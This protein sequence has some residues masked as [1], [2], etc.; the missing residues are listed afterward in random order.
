MS[1]HASKQLSWL[2]RHGAGE[3]GL[4]MDAA[5]WAEIADVLRALDMSRAALMEAVEHNDKGRL[6]VRGGR[7]R[8]CQGHSLAGMPVTAEALE[9]TWTPREGDAPVWHGTRTA[10]LAGIAREGILPGARTHVHLAEAID[11][12]VGKRAAVDVMLEVAPARLREAGIGLFQS[13]NGVILA[14]RV[15]AACI[16]GLVP[17]VEKARRREAELT[18]LLGLGPR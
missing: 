5:G 8:A 12:V 11:S 1:K 4:E 15:P 10:A 14:R 18:A 13:P 9:A 17:M 2:L 3:V 16:V 7:I 6:E